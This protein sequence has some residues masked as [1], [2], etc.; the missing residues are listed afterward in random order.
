MKLIMK[1]VVYCIVI[2]VTKADLP[3]PVEECS[4]ENGPIGK[5]RIINCR[6]KSL[7]SV[8]KFQPSDEI[9]LELTLSNSYDPVLLSNGAQC[10]S[11]NKITFL[12]PTAFRGLRLQGLDLSKNQISQ[13]SDT[14]FEGLESYLEELSID[15]D[16][17][18]SPPYSAMSRLSNLKSL[19]LRHFNQAHM[20]RQ[21]TMI[22]TLV[23][24]ET[25]ELKYMDVSVFSNDLFLYRLPN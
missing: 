13:V 11:C 15:G 1:I 24:L 25:L 8:P 10:P 7:T 16:K 22:D 6:D 2:I 18:I 9:F 17:T 21:N 20:N 12:P 23:N 4:C 5:G 14:A 3:C 19:S